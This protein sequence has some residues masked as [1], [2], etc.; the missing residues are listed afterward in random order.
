[1][2]FIKYLNKLQ[3]PQQQY[4]IILFYDCEARINVLF[5]YLKYL[6]LLKYSL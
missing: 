4:R 3:I 1:M 6:F 2:L 5:N